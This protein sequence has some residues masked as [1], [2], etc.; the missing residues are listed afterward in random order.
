[1][2]LAYS[3]VGLAATEE[4]T[5]D[6]EDMSDPMAI[7]SQI[8]AGV[9]NKGL[10][11]KI[12]NTYDTGSDTQLG[13]NIVE[14]KGIFGEAVGWDG[15]SVRNDSIDSFRFRNFTVDTTTGR[16]AQI[17][18]NINTKVDTGSASYGFIQALP[19]MGP[20]KLYPLVGLGV[21]IENND[22][23]GYLIPG[24]YGLVGMYGKLEIT[25]KLWLNYNPFWFS[26]LSGSDTYKQT[27]MQ[28]SD[29]VVTHEFV[30]SY[31]FTP[32]FN[33]RA[34]ANW[35]ENINLSDGD[36]RLEFNYQF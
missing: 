4:S 20:F 6:V 21:S 27:G 13:M 8:G 12:G 28:G 10:N 9:S 34:F 31:Q 14:L 23:M 17:D 18:I 11:L 29:S 5:G 7:Y 19:E 16:G 32:R 15:S 2:L 25:D 36:H 24:A 22:E 26:T 3:S 35:S 30:V 1:M 33:L